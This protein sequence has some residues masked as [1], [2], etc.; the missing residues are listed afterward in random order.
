MDDV[1]RLVRAMTESEELQRVIEVAEDRIKELEGGAKAARTD[2]SDLEVFS[3]NTG[4]REAL[5][6]HLSPVD[7]IRLGACSRGMRRGMASSNGRPLWHTFIARRTQRIVRYFWT[8]T[9][10]GG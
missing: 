2:F 7:V 6:S 1:T 10:R 9:R 5:L 8:D 4:F 3:R